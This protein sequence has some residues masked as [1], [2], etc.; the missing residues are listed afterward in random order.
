MA[1]D[2]SYNEGLEKGCDEGREEDMSEAKASVALAMLKEGFSQ[3]NIIALTGLSK[4]ARGL[5]DGGIC[6]RAVEKS[7]RFQMISGG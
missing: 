3:E 6:G 5:L 7:V 4:G 2:Y 1:L